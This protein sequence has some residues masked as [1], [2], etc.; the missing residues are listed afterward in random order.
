[1]P[2]CKPFLNQISVNLF[3]ATSNRL[4]VSPSIQEGEYIYS[5]SDTQ[6]FWITIV[7][8]CLLPC[9]TYAVFY[10][11]LGTWK[12][13]LVFVALEI[14]VLAFKYAKYINVKHGST[15]VERELTESDR[16]VGRVGELIDDSQSIID[17]IRKRN[18]GQ[19]PGS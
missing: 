15:T 2:R 11:G 5:L 3:R 4:L 19:S 14:V 6:F 1:M 8:L 10:L 16:A 17:G 9:V 12:E 13:Y 18:E 7:W